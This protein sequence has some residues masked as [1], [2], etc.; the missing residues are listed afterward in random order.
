MKIFF[1]LF[2]LIVTENYSQSAS[3]TFY[4]KGDSE[5]QFSRDG[6]FLFYDEIDNS[7]KV[8]EPNGLELKYQIKTPENFIFCNIRELSNGG[9]LVSLRGG[10]IKEKI[11]KR[12]SYRKKIN[13]EYIKKI[14]S[15]STPYVITKNIN[16]Y[17]FQDGNLIKTKLFSHSNLG[18]YLDAT[19]KIVTTKFSKNYQTFFLNFNKNPLIKFYNGSK[20]YEITY[21]QNN[22]GTFYLT[23]INPS[24]NLTR[25]VKLNVK[26]F[27]NSK[28][29]FLEDF[30]YQ[31]KNF[32]LLEVEDKSFKI[33]TRFQSSSRKTPYQK[34]RIY[35][36]DYNGRIIKE[37][38]F[39]FKSKHKGY[40]FLDFN[41]RFSESELYEGVN[42]KKSIYKFLPSLY[43]N[44]RVHFLKDNSFISY[45][46]LIDEHKK[47]LLLQVNKYDKESNLLWSEEYKILDEIP[48][49]ISGSEL[50]IQSLLFG[51]SLFFSVNYQSYIDRKSVV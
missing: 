3:R 10:L 23:L 32:Y 26:P 51:D 30:K 21:H 42:S 33:L 13:N 47:V 6:H 35:E 36:I 17:L 46:T 19:H 5:I 49:D 24:L 44:N 28:V 1:L 31:N 48:D 38:N 11:F 39:L 20:S 8:Y 37:Y 16:D 45:S 22:K 2:L 40:S 18:L 4:L 43:T 7:V 12:K 25:V 14:D 9:N 29:D 50:I 27:K 34:N 15:F 41:S